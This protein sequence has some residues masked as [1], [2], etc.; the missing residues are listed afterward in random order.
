[1]ERIVKGYRACYDD[2]DANWQAESE[3]LLSLGAVS[4]TARFTGDRGS[5]ILPADDR[6]LGFDP[7]PVST[8]LPDSATQEWP[9]GDVAGSS[10]AASAVD[11]TLVA[12]AIDA[13]FRGDLTA[14]AAVVVLHRGEIVGE[15]YRDGIHAHTQL[16]SWSMGKSLTGTLIGVLIQQGHLSLELRHIGHMPR[17]IVHGP[18]LAAR[19]GC[20]L[21][22]A[23]A[24]TGAPGSPTPTPSHG[25]SPPPTRT[26]AASSGTCT[27]A[28]DNDRHPRRGRHRPRRPWR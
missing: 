27:T 18:L 28:P 22:W 6:P 17:D 13:G 12:A 19:P 10:A 23:G 8:T 9:M 2:L 21:R 24:S 5:V 11:R 1:V 16:E 20:P 25:S 26:A 4:R 15:R 14:T 7:V 3:R